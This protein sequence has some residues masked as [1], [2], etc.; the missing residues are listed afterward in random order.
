MFTYG[1]VVIYMHTGA[2]G[3]IA[4]VPPKDPKAPL[5]VRFPSGELKVI[6]KEDLELR[7]YLV[8]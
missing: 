3:V 1:T 7:G 4:A 2:Q 5:L 8:D 6:W